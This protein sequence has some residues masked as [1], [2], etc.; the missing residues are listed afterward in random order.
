MIYN[1]CMC[2][3]IGNIGICVTAR[4]QR[5]KSLFMSATSENY[6]LLFTILIKKSIEATVLLF[7][8]FNYNNWQMP[9][10]QCLIL[11]ISLLHVITWG[12]RY[13]LGVRKRLKHIDKRNSSYKALYVPNT[14]FVIIFVNN[15]RKYQCSGVNLLM[16]PPLQ[17]VTG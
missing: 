11:L 14:C 13:P 7:C 1:T 3:L 8:T 16:I 2:K 6:S 9:H 5:Y 12:C 4:N 10:K 15:M 17:V